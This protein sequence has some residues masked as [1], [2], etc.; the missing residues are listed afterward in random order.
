AR[1]SLGHPSAP[2]TPA[3]AA[4]TAERSQLGRK[5]LTRCCRHTRCLS[6]CPKAR[7]RRRKISFERLGQMTKQKSVRW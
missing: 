5:T 7:W 2:S 6:T 4:L 3:A 1:P